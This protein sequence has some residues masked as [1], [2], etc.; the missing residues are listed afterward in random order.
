[1]Y[2][3]AYLY[4]KPPYAGQ[5]SSFG[6]PLDPSHSGTVRQ[7]E[8]LY[9]DPGCG[10]E[11]LGQIGSGL[12]FLQLTLAGP[13]LPLQ[14]GSGVTASTPEDSPSVPGLPVS[15]PSSYLMKCLDLY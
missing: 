5:Q 2:D 11:F 1:M 7:V 10:F 8:S 13:L 9:P 6:D 3:L 15:S 14:S 4:T 12:A